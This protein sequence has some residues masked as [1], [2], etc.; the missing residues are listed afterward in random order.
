MAVWLRR[1]GLK[2]DSYTATNNAY[3]KH[4][5]YHNIKSEYNGIAFDSNF[6]LE[7]YKKLLDFKAKGLLLDVEAHPNSIEVV[8]SST[9]QISELNKRT[10]KYTTKERVLFN[11]TDFNP[12]F[13]LVLNSGKIFYLD[14]KSYATLT[15]AYK[16][17]IKLLYH[18]KGVICVT[19][20]KEHI[21]NMELLLKALEAGSFLQFF[22]KSGN[23]R[24]F[25][26]LREGRFKI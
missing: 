14:S 22:N 23:V 12:D 16:I 1:Y 6:E 17:K 19:A 25:K 13:K 20:F 8:P 4:T 11:N 9:I 15:D 3:E 21:D 24:F 18:L 7:V 2:K 26:E 5:R 10:N